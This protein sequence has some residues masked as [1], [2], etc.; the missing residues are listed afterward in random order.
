MAPA[1]PHEPFPDTRRFW[2]MVE[3]TLRTVFERPADAAEGLADELAALPAEEQLLFYHAE[4]LDVAADLADVVPDEDQTR[5]Y[6]DLAR[7]TGWWP[8][9]PPRARPRGDSTA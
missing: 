9:E 7:R 2:R 4:P 8:A 5:R 6:A 1:D 3:A